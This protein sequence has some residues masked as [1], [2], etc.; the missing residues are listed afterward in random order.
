MHLPIAQWSIDISSVDSAAA[1]LAPLLARLVD[2]ERSRPDRRLWDLATMRQLLQ[3]PGF[4]ALVRPAVQVGGS[5]GKGTTCGY[6]EALAQ[7]AGRRPGVYSSPHLETLLER[8]RCGG[9]NVELT[10]LEPVLRAIV[11]GAGGERAPTFFEAMTAAAAEC[12]ARDG[13]DFAIYE[14]GLGGRFDATTAIPVDVS[15]ITSIELEHT[16]V[17]GRTVEAIA[18]EKSVIVRPGGVGVTAARGAAL[19]VIR[20]HAADV[21]ARLL[22]FD[23]DFGCREVLFD[24]YDWTFRLWLPGGEERL[25]R[26]SGGAGF[27]LPAVALAATACTAAAPGLRLQ[28]DPLPRPVL[29]GRFEILAEPDGTALVLDGAHT[30]DSLAAVARE[31]RRRWPDQRPSVLFASATGKRWRAGLSELLPLVD[32]I[33]VTELVGTSSEDP[34]VIAK[35]IATRGVSVEQAVDVEA[36]LTALRQKPGPRVVVGS[37]Y[38][39]G[40]VRALVT[41][42]R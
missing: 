5:K 28:L 20:A 27:E 16:C 40:Q 21:G 22:V 1:H 23:E 36:G 25:V 12:F 9:S 7:A 15:V 8:I 2:H 39:V 30:R 29:P 38:L 26:M 31:L 34:A 18:A 35:W 11:D 6:L 17:L 37:F 4:S 41:N 14:V 32:S 13:V 24:G 33:V 3:R 42:D 19:D 10:R